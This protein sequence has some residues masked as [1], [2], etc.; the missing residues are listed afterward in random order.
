VFA[1]FAKHEVLMML[2]REDAWAGLTMAVRTMQLGTLAGDPPPPPPL[3]LP[4]LGICK[5]KH[6]PL[7]SSRFLKLDN[8]RLRITM[9][10]KG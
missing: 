4:F 8:C 5:S 10:G 9:I 7:Q 1:E 3:P 6:A 2:L